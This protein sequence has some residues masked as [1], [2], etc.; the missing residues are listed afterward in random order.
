M[1]TQP[2]EQFPG[3]WGRA[4]ALVEV[5]KGVG[6]PQVVRS[7]PLRDR[8][9]PFK[10][11]NGFGD[12]VLVGERTRSDEAALRHESG[13]GRALTQLLPQRIDVHPPALGA[14]AVGQHRM[15]LRAA[16]QA[17]EPFK[18]LRRGVI[19]AQAVLGQ[20]HE[21]DHLG[22][23]WSPLVERGQDAAGVIEVVLVELPSRLVESGRGTSTGPFTESPD[24]HRF[25]LGK[26]GRCHGKRGPIDGR[27][28]TFPASYGAGTFDG[29]LGLAA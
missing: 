9:P 8:P 15:L 22:D 2:A 23:V 13:T 17:P 3:T 1:P 29:P 20:T 28:R 19:P 4:G 18:R 6:A 7:G 16:G 26:A 24:E 14:I 12:P 10:E 25:R 21:F 11:V 5:G 27:L